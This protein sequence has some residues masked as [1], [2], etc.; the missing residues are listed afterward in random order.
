[1]LVLT[2]SNHTQSRKRNFRSNF[3]I[4]KE[5]VPKYM[6][7]RTGR[8]VPLNFSLRLL[9]FQSKQLLTEY[10]EISTH[11]SYESLSNKLQFY[12]IFNFP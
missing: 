7:Q 1:M 8:A 6:Y 2:M 12:F 4:P 5:Q 3:N 9:W 11:K 10:Y